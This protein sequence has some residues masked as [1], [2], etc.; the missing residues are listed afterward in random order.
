[1][2]GR[3]F[4]G[5]EGSAVAD[6]VLG[7]AIIVFVVLPVFSAVIERYIVINKAQV[8]KDAVDMTNISAYNALDADALSRTAITLDNGE[9][10]DIYKSLLAENLRLKADMTPDTGSVAD[11]KVAIDSII[12]Y[13]DDFP[14]ACPGGISIKR[15]SIHSHVTV[16]VKPSLYRQVILQI[17]GKEYV[18]LE[19]HVDSDIPLNN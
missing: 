4:S 14:Q 11:D 1:M 15:P 16:P 2:K 18:E 19:V 3:I 5:I 13:L 10:M 8:I 12:V 9:I 7:A 17:L 6:V